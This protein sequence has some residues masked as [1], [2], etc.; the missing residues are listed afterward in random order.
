[1]E[2]CSQEVL[3]VSSLVNTLVVKYSVGCPLEEID[4][5]KNGREIYNTIRW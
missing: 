1:M 2:I 5:R 3:T 4:Q